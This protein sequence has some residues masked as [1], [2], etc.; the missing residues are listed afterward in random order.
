M[1]K[2]LLLFSG[3]IAATINFAQNIPNGNFESALTNGWN[4][5]PSGAT[6][7]TATPVPS[8]KGQKQV[9]TL[10]TY[11]VGS[12]T[13]GAI[14]SSSATNPGNI[15]ATPTGSFTVSVADTNLRPKTLTGFL[16]YLPTGLDTAII[17]VDLIKGGSIIGGTGDGTGNQ[18]YE[19]LSTPSW[20]SVNMPLTYTNTTDLPDS[21][22]IVIMSSKNASSTNVGSTLLVDNLR[23]LSCTPNPAITLTSTYNSDPHATIRDY[24]QNTDSRVYNTQV[25]TKAIIN[26]TTI[27][28]AGITATISPLDSVIWDP[29]SFPTGS[30]LTYIPGHPSGVSYGN[31]VYCFTVLGGNL[32]PANDTAFVMPNKSTIYGVGH[33]TF[34]APFNTISL[35][36]SLGTTVNTA[37]QPLDSIIVV[38]GTPD[39][40]P[41][42]TTTPHGA[43]TDKSA[44]SGGDVTSD[45]HDAATTRGI[46]YSTGIKR[47]TIAD[48]VITD[49][50][51]GA[52]TYTVTIT[53]LTPTTKYYI[54]AY[55]TNKV[56]TSYGQPDSIITLVPTG[57]STFIIKN[58]IQVYP[59]PSA[60]VFKVQSVNGEISNSQIEVYNSIGENVFHTN[61]KQLTNSII[62]LSSNTKG[63]Y[64]LIIKSDNTIIFR[65]SII[66][67]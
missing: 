26:P 58:S 45:G 50:G 7:S 30:T 8:L 35:P 64:F 66:V 1:K 28:I 43:V 61:V 25:F 47:P 59:N 48:S 6:T 46:C 62:D 52:G 57:V 44:V 56:G 67:Q 33:T 41:K 11:S 60:G 63:I 10:T 13:A 36:F 5:T 20:T 38:F 53:G 24:R 2:S 29:I 18:G 14:V 32:P 42:V 39:S 31:S 34:Q 55:A 23:F 22:R 9:L 21:I 49:S 12:V 40:V 54:R 19:I 65:Q 15:S 16:K 17:F 37:H 4:A 51:T 27:A 3:L